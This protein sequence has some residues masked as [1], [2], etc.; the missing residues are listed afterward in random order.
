M[1]FLANENFPGDAVR[2]IEAKGHDIVWIR[3]AAPGSADQACRQ[4]TGLGPQGLTNEQ[5]GLDPVIEPGRVRMRP[6]LAQKW[7]EYCLLRWFVDRGCRQLPPLSNPCST[8]SWT[9]LMRQTTAGEYRIEGRSHV[10]AFSPQARGHSK[11]INLVLLPP[12]PFIAGCVVLL[13]VNG[14]QR[15][16]EFV[17]DLEPKAPGLCEADVMGVARRSPTNEAGL[18]GHIAQMLLGSDSFWLADSEDTLVDFWTCTIVDSLVWCRLAVLRFNNLGKESCFRLLLRARTVSTFCS[19]I[20]NRISISWVSVIAFRKV[21]ANSLGLSKL[22]SSEPDAERRTTGL[23][24]AK[25]SRLA[26]CGRQAARHHKVQNRMIAK[27]GKR[28]LGGICLGTFERKLVSLPW[29]AALPSPVP[30]PSHF[31]GPKAQKMN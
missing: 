1:R 29:V 22:A 23:S 12:Q 27:G 19:Q 26:P 4:R 16:R 21:A 10:L 9:P 14:A 18:L 2:A 11:R 7:L 20:A 17:T 3:T 25:P 31:P 6:L 15:Y 8:R 24:A 5:I 28:T 13:M 30:D